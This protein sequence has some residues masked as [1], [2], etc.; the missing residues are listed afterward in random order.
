LLHTVTPEKSI[1]I[2]RWLISK[3]SAKAGI[4]SIII[5]SAFRVQ[6]S[7]VIRHRFSYFVFYGL[8]GLACPLGE[9]WNSIRLT[10]D[11]IAKK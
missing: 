10:L 7:K 11:T 1:L 6:G 5:G 4:N 3:S 2:K 8:N 9:T